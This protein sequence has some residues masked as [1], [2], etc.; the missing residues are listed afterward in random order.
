MTQRDNG[1]GDRTSSDVVSERATNLKEA[2]RQ[3]VSKAWVKQRYAPLAETS[4]ELDA[5]LK[6]MDGQN[7]TNET[8]V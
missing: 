4:P 3:S 1:V 6:R 8:K 7:E 2:I 5:L